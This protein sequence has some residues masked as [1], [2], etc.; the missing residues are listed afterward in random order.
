MS[1]KE[2]QSKQF[3]DV[4]VWALE[5]EQ[6]QKLTKSYQNLKSAL[7]YFSSCLG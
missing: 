3:Q 6:C 7:N 1:T 5:A 2:P 4:K